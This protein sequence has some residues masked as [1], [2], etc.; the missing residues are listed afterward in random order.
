MPV[1]YALFLKRLVIDRSLGTS[2]TNRRNV[3]QTILDAAPVTASLVFGGAI[4]W[5]LIAL[6][7]GILSALR[8]RSLMDRAATVFVLIGISL[9]VV[10]IGLVLQYAIGYRLGWF[11]NA[12]LLRLHQSRGDRDLWR[13]RRSGPTTSCCRG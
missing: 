9:P 5:M 12:G 11:P 3:T 10:L 2:F 8:P 7:I 1:Q 4:L 13:S 6:P